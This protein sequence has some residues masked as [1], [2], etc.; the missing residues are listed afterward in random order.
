[1]CLIFLPGDDSSS[2]DNE[3]PVPRIAGILSACCKQRARHPKE[4][5]DGS[6]GEESVSNSSAPAESSCGEE[7]EEDI[8]GASES[9]DVSTS[10]F[11]DDEAMEVELSSEEWEEGSGESE[12]D[13]EEDGFV[14]EEAMDEDVYQAKKRTRRARARILSDTESNT[15]SESEKLVPKKARS[16]DDGVVKTK[17]VFLAD[18]DEDGEVGANGVVME[19]K[20]EDDAGDSS[21]EE[22]EESDNS[23]EVTESSNNDVSSKS[24]AN[25][26]SEPLGG[27]GAT[28]TTSRGE[29]FGTRWKQ[30]LAMQAS[31]TY[32]RRLSSTTNLR[33]LIYSK[34]PLP[35]EDAG[36]NGEAEDPRE[37]GGLFQLTKKRAITIFH[38]ED[39]SLVCDS[40]PTSRDWSAPA[41]VSAAKNLF[42]TGNW[43]AEGAQALLDEDDVLYGDF[44]D[45]EGGE[46]E[47]G[48]TAEVEEE[49]EEDLGK[50]RLEKKKKLKAAFDVGYDEEDGDGG[51]YLDDLKR[52]VSEQ[53]RRNR[54]EFEG[55][56][57][58]ACLQYEGMR[59]GYYVRL[60]LK[61]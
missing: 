56:D 7:A 26:E 25:L 42:V 16:S 8:S 12:E 23:D 6:G 39:T 14:I 31:T 52:E 40:A 44:E 47:D 22:E 28:I 9:A 33:R 55:M 11:L 29:Q 51:T 48:H 57:E 60:E 3:E 45:I 27:G 35:G 24:D 53:E 20:R 59:P 46:K 50:K 43:G 2:S 34:T 38:K 61:G 15:G 5:T 1:M 49:N 21:L 54:E 4:L 18:S 30:D 17:R 36:E 10:G 58:R 32:S 41:T 13:W 37:I 19:A